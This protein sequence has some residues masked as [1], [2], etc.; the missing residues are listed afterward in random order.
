M[1]NFPLTNYDAPF[2]FVLDDAA[3]TLCRVLGS[4]G[5]FLDEEDALP[6]HPNIIHSQGSFEINIDGVGVGVCQTASDALLMWGASFYV[7][8]KKCPKMSKKPIVVP[9]EVYISNTSGRR[10]TRPAGGGTGSGF[11]EAMMTTDWWVMWMA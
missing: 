6:N 7:F 11:G 3:E 4:S 1:I 2:C 5:V 10:A 8:D 9:S